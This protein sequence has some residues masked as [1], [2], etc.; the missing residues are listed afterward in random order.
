[1]S[2]PR[3]V[4][5]DIRKFMGFY[6]KSSFSSFSSG[7][8]E[9]LDRRVAREIRYSTPNKKRSR[10]IFD[11][12]SL[13]RNVF[14]SPISTL[15]EFGGNDLD[16]QEEEEAVEEHVFFRDEIAAEMNFDP[17]LRSN[18]LVFGVPKDLHEDDMQEIQESVSGELPLGGYIEV[19]PSKALKENDDTLAWQ[20]HACI[21]HYKKHYRDIN[22]KLENAGHLQKF[23]MSAKPNKLPGLSSQLSELHTWD[24]GLKE[25]CLKH[26]PDAHDI[27][28]DEEVR[29][30]ILPEPAALARILQKEGNTESATES[31][32]LDA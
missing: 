30:P 12:E 8:T 14:I 18:N 26:C 3:N 21:K 2:E 25:Y 7:F 5:T 22:T 16:A 4:V 23:S 32:I 29:Y 9:S 17:E 10:Q 27:W 15:R 31:D 24:A 6:D 28:N 20:I 1:M 11:G 13:D 19:D